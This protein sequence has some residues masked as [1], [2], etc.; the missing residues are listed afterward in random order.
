MQRL[1]RVLVFVSVAVLL[2]G[3]GKGCKGGKPEDSGESGGDS[4][5]KKA[6]YILKELASKTLEPSG[7]EQTVSYKD[8]VRVVLPGGTLKAKES[9]SISSIE[10]APP[11]NMKHLAELSCFDV[12]V[13]KTRVFEKPVT[14]EF[15]YDP[16]KVKGELPPE[17]GLLAGYWDE[18]AQVW[19]VMPVV[20][21]TEK[22]V[23]RVQTMHLCPW[24]LYYVA[25]GYTV[26]Y[27]DHFKIVYDAKATVTVT[28]PHPRKPGEMMPQQ[29]AGD[30]FA[31][32][33]VSYLEHA[34]EQYST[35]GYK[36][37][38]WGQIEGSIYNTGMR[39]WVF[40]NIE[41][42]LVRKA[43][44]Q[45]SYRS[46]FSGAIYMADN[47]D[48]MDSVR[49]E[50]AHELFHC[51]QNEYMNIASLGRRMWWAEATADYA[52]VRIAWNLPGTLMGEDIGF[53]YIEESLT[54]VGQPGTPHQLHEYKTSHLV[55]WMVRNGADFKA[56]WE[57]TMDCPVPL[58]VLVPL[59]A[60][61]TKATHKGL[62]SHYTDFAAWL[63]F[64]PT[65]PVPTGDP[66]E[67]AFAKDVLNEAQGGLPPRTFELKPDCTAQL[68]GIKPEVAAQGGG[69]RS[70]VVE[71]SDISGKGCWVSIFV[72]K[73]N[74]RQ[75]GTAHV[76]RLFD[77]GDQ[78]AVS[79]AA[80]DVLYILPVN[81]SWLDLNK[82]TLRV[83]S[84]VLN[85]KAP[86]V[87]GESGKAGKEY[88]F[89]VVT[90]GAGLPKDAVIAWDFGDGSSAEGMQ[91]KHRFTDEGE[92]KVRARTAVGELKLEA[93]LQ[94][95][96]GGSAGRLEIVREYYPD[97]TLR[98]EYGLYHEAGEDGAEYYQGPYTT[99]HKNGKLMAIYTYVKGEQNGPFESWRDDG[100]LIIKG[101]YKNGLLEGRCMEMGGMRMDGS[102]FYKREAEFRA[103]KL[104]G[105]CREWNKDDV[106]VAEGTYADN[107]L[108]GPWKSWHDDG[109][110]RSEGRFVNGQMDGTWKNWGE[111]QSD[112]GTTIH[113]LQTETVY[114]MGTEIST[115]RYNS[116]KE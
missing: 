98:C 80:G 92:Y 32:R 45:T 70:I 41:D 68:W 46:G 104:H 17:D 15:A 95:P 27:S 24:R 9:V 90:E 28:V 110:P 52:A 76:A 106:L 113:W 5:P 83:T 112:K 74:V 105:L 21:D 63:L 29:Q 100:T 48:S 62:A 94:F 42:Q 53:K 11:T 86:L 72:L 61:L 31:Q 10:N 16:E 50:T 33:V 51:V 99:W 91:V 79:V 36:M 73:G 57:A 89:S 81:T 12:S 2:T 20:V 26:R 103:H 101:T 25:K 84:P 35:K 40:V 87:K 58:T 67:S 78:A 75:S 60:Y 108:N 59:D 14:L 23:A 34:Y 6:Q 49:Y 66:Y 82:I 93:F 65:G 85:I 13:G 30:E 22:K 55:D 47:F 3:C 71:L 88:A 1:M 7:Q 44:T 56:M 114:K 4:K 115:K 54:H 19:R 97:K 77:K 64:D 69:T 38:F 116:P 39:I 107:E 37:P 109:K 43:S 102:R 111:M 96:V 8:E 18:D